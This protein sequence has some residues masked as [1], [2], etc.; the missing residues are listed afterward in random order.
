MEDFIRLNLSSIIAVCI[1]TLLSIIFYIAFLNLELIKK[2]FRKYIHISFFIIL[3]IIYV[4]FS[5]RIV[6]H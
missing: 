2:E 1:L 4:L 6:Y 3:L 5:I